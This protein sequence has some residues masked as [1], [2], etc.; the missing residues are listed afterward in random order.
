MSFGFWYPV[1]LVIDF[2]SAHTVVVAD[3]HRA[4]LR[5][6]TRVALLQPGRTGA[7]PALPEVLAIGE[8]TAQLP[9]REA[10]YARIVVP[11]ER[12]R[13]S[14]GY[15]LVQLLRALLRRLRAGRFAALQRLGAAGLLLPPGLTPEE[16]ERFRAVLLEAGLSRLVPLAAPLA[17]ARGCGLALD[18]PR[19][20]MLIEIGAGKTI[21]AVLSLGGLVACHTLPF[22]GLDLDQAILN[23]VERRLHVALTAE[24]ATWIK[25]RY[26]SVYPRERPETIE[27]HGVD[28]RTNR[29]RRVLL[30]D[31]QLREL[32]VDGCEPLVL[33]IQRTFEQ[34]PPEL[35]GDIARQGILL[36]GGG[37]LLQGL[38]EYLGERTGVHYRVVDSPAERTRQGA[39]VLLHDALRPPPGA[40][41][42][43]A[44]TAGAL[45]LWAGRS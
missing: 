24:T 33:A 18:E 45:G 39:L 21:L 30:D 36:L 31:N 38:P 32:L 37:A 3:D 16:Q 26:G 34:V 27:A 4:P 6:R 42:G 28:P 14:D 44:R 5:D 22:G 15:A 20:H 1:H 13:I 2:G 19:G 8:E 35:A 11:I 9:P 23:D 12:G 43:G 17:A 40:R 10:K 7:P 25:H 29:E 41:T